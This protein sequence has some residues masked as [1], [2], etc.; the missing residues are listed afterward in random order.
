MKCDTHRIE[1]LSN[2]AV[3]NVFV[4]DR[5]LLRTG[6]I[7]RTLAVLVISLLIFLATGCGGGS[8][9]SVP[10]PADTPS[11]SLSSLVSGLSSPLDFQVPDDNSGRIFIVQQRGT[12]RII[13]NGSLLS[14]AFLDITSKV[15]F[16]SAEQGLLGLAFHPN[17][18]QNSRFYLN[19][20]RLLP[21]GQIQTVIAEYQLSTDP[22]QADPASER[23]LLTVD[24]PL[25]ITKA[26][27]WPLGRT[28]FFTLVWAT[29]VV[30]AIRWATGK[31][32]RLCWARF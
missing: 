22:N 29:A 3:L 30:G 26:D 9:S 11:L 2:T 8:S 31:V 25:P 14:T 7:Y 15:N 20:D 19:Y 24:S 21:G 6:F 23:I 5:T 17:Y 16:D 10:P 13:N 32:S 1:S 12:I 4:I 27:N 18:G 28:D